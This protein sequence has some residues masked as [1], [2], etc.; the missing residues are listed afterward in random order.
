MENY[1]MKLC[2][3][4]AAYVPVEWNEWYEEAAKL[5][6]ARIDNVEEKRGERER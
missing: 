5:L 2:H 6:F 4:L 3:C 1:E